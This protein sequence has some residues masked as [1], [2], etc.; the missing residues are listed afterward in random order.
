M[1]GLDLDLQTL[2]R[3]GVRAVALATGIRPDAREGGGSAQAIPA[4]LLAAQL[5]GFLVEA[6]IL[7]WKTGLLVSEENVRTVARKAGALASRHLVVEAVLRPGGGASPLPNGAMDAFKRVLLPVASLLVANR[8]EAELLAGLE[9]NSRE[10]FREAALRLRK[11]GPGAVVIS[12]APGEGSGSTVDIASLNDGFHEIARE[13][14]RPM[15]LLPN[16]YAAAIS[17]CLARGFPLRD[18]LQLARSPHAGVAHGAGLGPK[19]KNPL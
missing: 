1:T 3:F 17:A 12:G 7:A 13:G 11:L 15:T 2:E 19:M 6:G 16:A 9:L 5:D 4:T 14:P 8:R 10:D 18:A